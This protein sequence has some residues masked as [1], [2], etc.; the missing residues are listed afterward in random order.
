MQRFNLW[1]IEMFL[2]I[3]FNLEYN[4]NR[5]F[6]TST[7]IYRQQTKA[8]KAVLVIFGPHVINN[9]NSNLIC[10]ALI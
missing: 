6:E 5:Y 4:N 8:D 9:N 3:V 7:F 1:E 2:N 10:I